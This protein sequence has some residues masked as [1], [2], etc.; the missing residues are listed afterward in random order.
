MKKR[1]MSVCNVCPHNRDIQR[2][3]Q[4]LL[5]WTREMERLRNVCGACS[6]SSSTSGKNLHIDAYED[7]ELAE[8]KLRRDQVAL[9]NS[10][11][12]FASRIAVRDE[13]TADLLKRV[14]AEF[15]ALTDEEA[16]IVVR[17][18]RGETNL[19]ITVATGLS[20][21]TVWR[22]WNNLIKKNPLWAVLKNGNEDLRGG[23]RHKADADDDATPPP[24][25]VQRDLL[26][27]SIN[28]WGR[29]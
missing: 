29:K 23:G 27:G 12:S 7:E 9:Y 5:K 6:G 24:E 2:A 13:E 3:E 1:T 14:V 21:Q 18:L 26:D 22:R 10:R 4:E 17:K 16:P 15:S 25:Y 8:K 11:Q 19:E 28:D 20:K